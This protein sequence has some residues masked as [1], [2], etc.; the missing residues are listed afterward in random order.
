ML[1]LGRLAAC[2][3]APLDYRAC[4]CT[5][6]YVCCQ[7]D[8][9][10]LRPGQICVGAGPWPVPGEP[11]APPVPLDDATVFAFSHVNSNVDLGMVDDPQLI[12]L[13]PDVVVRAWAQWGPYGTGKDQYQFPYIARCHA[14]GVRYFMGGATATVLL[15]DQ[16]TTH[17]EFEDFATRDAAGELVVHDDIHAGLYRATLANPKVRE[18]LLKIGR[19]QIDGGV[20][21]LHFAE[22]NHAFQGADRLGNEG[23]DDYHLA[24]FNAFLL[25]R[26]PAGT[27]FRALFGMTTDN[28]LRHDVPPG[29]LRANFDYRAYLAARDLTARPLSPDN[30][31][32]WLWGRTVVNRPAPGDGTFV[33]QAD[34]Y[35]YWRQITGELRAYARGLGRTLVISA[36]GIYPLVDFQSVG[37]EVTN[38]DGPGETSVD[39]VPL[40]A[41]GQHLDGAVSLKD[42]FLRLKSR[43]E[44]LAP[45][46]PVVLFLDG[47]WPR[48]QGFPAGSRDRADFWRL[49]AAEAYANGLFFAFHLRSSVGDPPEATAT[50][51][52][53]MPLFQAL[54]GFYRAHADLYHGAVA[55][56]DAVATAALPGPM[57]TV[58]D[59][60]QRARRLVHVV[61]HHYAPGAGI[62]SHAGV[63]VT[64][65]V[66]QPPASVWVASP[67]AAGDVPLVDWS[68]D[69]A[70]GLVSV[71]LPSVD[72]YAVVVVSF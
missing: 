29:D 37:L 1:A 18:L 65:T 51:L 24:D 72:A 13:G 40:A 20:D 30:P 35:R 14:A 55:A 17:A 64:V 57:V 28:T 60:P 32:S 52:G 62:V 8:G 6:G 67:D 53:L 25:Q 16:A 22:I 19:I 69:P 2:E 4:P 39:Y 47:R 44:A 66:G 31:L 10:C 26:Y 5:D 9:V 68:Y 23:F 33:S 71:T 43:A 12:E 46:A 11:A 50:E 27:D 45:G 21:G 56:A 7:P 38:T 15:E 58:T 61:N 42:A 70:R 54:A 59:Q 49:Y 48:Y 63:A 34:P 41:D 36:E 3:P